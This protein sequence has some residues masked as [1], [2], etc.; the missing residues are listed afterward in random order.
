MSKASVSNLDPLPMKQTCAGLSMPK[1]STRSHPQYSLYHQRGRSKQVF[2]FLFC[3]GTWLMMAPHPTS[4]AFPLFSLLNHTQVG[5]HLRP[6]GCTREQVCVRPP[7]WPQS[8][9]RRERGASAV[10]PPAGGSV[11]AALQHLTRCFH[12]N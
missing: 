6:A 4:S 11:N 5:W 9:G 10:P 8:C 12:T 7:H 2:P 1:L 3:L